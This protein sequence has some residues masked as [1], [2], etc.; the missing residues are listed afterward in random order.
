MKYISE[1]ELNRIRTNANIVDIISSYGIKLT[2]TGKDN[3]LC[4]CPFH[5]DH[6][7]NM[8][9]SE[10]KQIYKC[11]GGCGAGGNVF[12]FVQ[13]IENISFVEAVKI[14]AEKS[15]QSFNFDVSGYKMENNKFKDEY[16]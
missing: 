13:D 2:K 1:E 9:V 5:D 15:G 6:N 16:N 14:V 11:F 3:Y 8:I 12:K 10:K 7:P 4:L